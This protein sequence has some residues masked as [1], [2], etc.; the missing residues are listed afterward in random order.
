[1][2]T[3]TAGNT[4][5][6]RMT[7]RQPTAEL[8]VIGGSGLYALLDDVVEVR[9]ETPYGSPSDALFVGEVAGRRV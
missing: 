7:D 8:G 2:T 9:V 5:A 4:G 6:E 3:T 1:M